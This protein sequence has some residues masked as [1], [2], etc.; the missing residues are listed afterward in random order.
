M[1]QGPVQAVRAALDPALL[2][3]GTIA[4]ALGWVSIGLGVV[5]IVRGGRLVGMFGGRRRGTL[6]L[7]GLREIGTGIGILNARD[8]GLWLWGRVAGDALDMLSLVRGFGRSPR[9][10]RRLLTLVSVGGIAALDI[11]SARR[12][13]Q[14]ALQRPPAEFAA[15]RSV[16]MQG[17]PADLLAAWSDPVRLAR[18]MAFLA[19]LE[20][21]A[22]GRTRWTIH[23][24]LG[25]EVPDHLLSWWTTA[26][27]GADRIVWTSDG[28]G[29]PVSGE[30]TVRAVQGAP[31]D[32]TVVTLALRFGP[33]DGLIGRTL[34]Q[35][36]QPLPIGQLVERAL[37]RFR[38]LVETG[39]LPTLM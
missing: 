13:G 14:S 15:R 33:A 20:A 17:R 6:R 10:G 22:D 7:Y 5:E 8:P 21:G 1:K 36:F 16:T 27:T 28:S 25:R 19:D 26:E 31:V 38:S 35:I 39:E 24:L 12:V 37:A 4:R 9:K 11:A 2:E 3:P 34:V 18:V 29:L 30:I 23:S 32:E